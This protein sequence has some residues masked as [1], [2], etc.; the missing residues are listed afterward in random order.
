MKKTRFILAAVISLIFSV[1]CLADGRYI[2]AEKLPAA[3][4]EFVK[5][6]F[7]DQKIIFAEK[8]AGKYEVKLNDG[9][10]AEFDSKGTWTKVDCNHNMLPDALLPQFTKNYIEVNFSGAYATK[11]EKKLYGYEVEMSNGLELKFN[12][13]GDLI[14][15]D[16]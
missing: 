9:T 3:A 11:I 1:A 12:R 2:P 16:D 5:E 6:H 14:N 7:P 4:K 8:E 13:L 15:I 10:E